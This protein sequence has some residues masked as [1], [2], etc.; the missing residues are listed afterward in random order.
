MF[1]SEQSHEWNSRRTERDTSSR[2]DIACEARRIVRHNADTRHIT[3][4]G[5]RFTEQIEAEANRSIHSANVAHRPGQT[6]RSRL[7]NQ[8]DSPRVGQTRRISTEDGQMGLI[9]TLC[10]GLVVGVIAKALMPGKDPGGIIIT[11]I[12]GIA[13]AF[14]G[15]WLG[16]MLGL[17][18]AGGQA[19][20]IA[21][22][23]GAMLLLFVYRM[24]KGKSTT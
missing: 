9:Y 16:Q 12:L 23:V 15:S 4:Q 24:I 3:Q 1:R 14:V 17:Y 6:L 21:S 13:G 19:G 22:I 5:W 11:I 20:W 7:P 18:P 2:R 10:I 8:P